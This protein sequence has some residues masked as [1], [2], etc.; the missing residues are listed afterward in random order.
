MMYK[1]RGLGCN[2]CEGEIVA[3]AL[4]LGESKFFK[5]LD[6]ETPLSTFIGNRYKV[7]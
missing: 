5:T 7:F 3:I 2:W 4:T 6:I 1:Y